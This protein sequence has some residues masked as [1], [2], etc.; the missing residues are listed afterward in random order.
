[1]VNYFT[2]FL[3]LLFVLE[4]FNLTYSFGGINRTFLAITRG[5]IEISVYY[6]AMPQGNYQ[7]YFEQ[8]VLENAV[9]EY[10]CENLSNY[11]DKYEISFYYYDVI[12]QS[13]CMNGHCDGVQIHLKTDIGSLLEYSKTL[14]FELHMK[15]ET[16]G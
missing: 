9:C 4:T 6:L 3:V 1:M 12:D 15:G 5:L 8:S 11:T 2:S 16:H 14:R 10:L 7:P 13:M